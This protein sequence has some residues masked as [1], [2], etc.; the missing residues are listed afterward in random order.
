MEY[1]RETLDLPDGAGVE[2]SIWIRQP[3]NLAGVPSLERRVAQHQL[4]AQQAQLELAKREHIADVRL[5]FYRALTAEMQANALREWGQ[6]LAAIVTAANRRVQVGE[7]SRFDLLRLQRERELLQGQMADAVLDAATAREYLSMRIGEDPGPVLTGTVL[8]P[9]LPPLSERELEN[10]PQLLFLK[11]GSESAALNTKAAKRRAWPEV[12]IGLGRKELTEPGLEADGNLVAVAVE[13]PLFDRNGGAARAAL[14]NQ[15]TLRAEYALARH[16]LQ[17]DAREAYRQL[18]A[19]RQAA[20]SVVGG[21]LSAIAE[22][23]YAAGEIDVAQL[24][25]AHQTDLATD[26]NRISRALRAREAY[27][28]LQQMKGTP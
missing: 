2:Q 6:R 5:M 26:L 1:S 10:H 28:Q 17:I 4:T 27:I 18:L 13:I 14:H 19:Q 7:T 15:H 25:N 3:L 22:D 16:R 21:A 24:I 9:E 8:P 20:V 23:A 12:T 11:A